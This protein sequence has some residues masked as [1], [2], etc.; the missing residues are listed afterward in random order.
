VSGKALGAYP[1]LG[2]VVVG[3]RPPAGARTLPRS[4][5][6]DRYLDEVPFTS[7]SNLIAALEVALGLATKARQERLVSGSRHARRRL[8]EAGLT[9]VADQALAAPHVL[10]I[11]LPLEV[12]S[13][14]VARRLAIRGFLV[15]HASQYLQRRN[16]IQICLMGEF[17][18]SAL[19]E[20]V[21]QLARE[22]STRASVYPPPIPTR[23]RSPTI[24][25]RGRQL[26]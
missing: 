10:T 1:G 3:D 5:D 18:L 8:A 12:N 21:C 7:S 14:T 23:V 24:G 19:D 13:T 22:A 4:L 20:A 9:V 17:T 26:S 2:M 15:A 11:A 6:L 16:W 25:G